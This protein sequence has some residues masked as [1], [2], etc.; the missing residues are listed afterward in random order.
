[1]V[2]RLHSFGIGVRLGVTLLVV[3]ILGGYAVSGVYLKWEYE[4]R[5]E[6]A[7]LT[8]DDVR[9]AYHGVR[10]ISP[11]ITAL[12]EGH[13][14]ELGHDLGDREREVLLE[15]LRGDRISE[16][17]DSLELGAYAPAE[18][19]AADCL[20]CHARGSTGE[21]ASP[22]SLE[23]WDDVEAV[24]YSREVSP[25]AVRVVAASTHAHAPTMALVLLMI[26]ALSVMTRFRPGFVG[27]CFALGAAALLADMSGQWLA[28]RAEVFVWAIVG[29]GFAYVASVG[30]LG[31]LVIA[32]CWLPTRP[33]PKDPLAG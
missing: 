8:V 4:N 1:M 26:G 12:E 24:A 31:L 27:F 13:P 19:I 15:W 32:E 14:E 6:R 2:P 9:G 10:S 25:K 28:R 16:Q 11:L 23:Y 30:V 5:D 17:Y 3:T 33:S 21:H 29:G 18:I 22:L 7:G 20:E